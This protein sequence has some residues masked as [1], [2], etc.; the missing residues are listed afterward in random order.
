[1]SM[2]ALRSN[3]CT[4]FCMSGRRFLLKVGSADYGRRFAVCVHIG[5]MKEADEIWRHNHHREL[6]FKDCECQYCNQWREE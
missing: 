6:P 1:M 5:R 4:N 3:E 2:T